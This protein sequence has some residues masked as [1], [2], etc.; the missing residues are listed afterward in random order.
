MVMKQNVMGKNLTQTIRNSITRYVAIVLIIALGAAMFVGLRTTK[1]DM[2]A[3]GQKYMDDQRMFDLRLLSTYG[4]D[5]DQVDAVKT[6]AGVEEAEGVITMDVI[7]SREDGREGVYKLYAIPQTLDQV[8][9]LGGR[10]PQAANECLA[11]GS[12]VGDAVLG[13]TYTISEGNEAD[14]LDSLTQRTFTVVGYISTPLF[15]DMNRGTTT[16]GNGTVTTYLYLPLEAFDVDYYTEIHVTLEGSHTVYTDAY[17]R[18]MEDLADALEPQLK[19]LAQNRYDRL[20][21]EAQEALDEGLAEYEEG[22]AEFMDGRQEA[23]DGLTEALKQLDDGQ[24]ELDANRQ[25]LL[26]GQTQLEDAQKLLDENSLTLAQSRQEL[27]QAKA[28]AYRQIAQVSAELTANYRQVNDGLRQVES[29]LTQ[30]NDGLVQINDGISQLESGLQTLE[31]TV[32]VVKSLVNVMDVTIDAAQSALDRLKENPEADPEQIAQAEARLQEARDKKAEYE[33]QL[34]ELEANQQ[35]YTAMLAEL[36]AQKETLES[37][38]AELVATRET[39]NAALA[40]IE[41]GFLE[42]ENSQKQADQ[43]FADAE[44]QLA[45]GQAQL[46]QGQKELDVNRAELEAGLE[47][48][49]VAQKELDAGREEYNTQRHEILRELADAQAKLDDAKAEL[50]DGRRQLADMKEP[51]LYLL[52]RNTNVGYISVNS[53]SDIV[54]GVSRVFPAF[55]LL[56]AALVCITTMTRMVA[57]ERTQIGTLKALGYGNG[58]IIGKYLAYAGS[59]AVLGSGL[60]VAVGSVVFPMILWEAYGIILNL[61]P[62]LELRLDWGLCAAVVVIYT[63]V[64]LAVTWYCCRMELREVPA[65]LIR[66]KAPTSGRKILLE[67]LPFW[68]HISFLNKVTLRNIF[69]YRQRLLMMMVGIGGCTALLVTGF[70]VKD[71]ITD[72]VNIQYEEVTRYDMEVRF[73]DG[74]TPEQ[75]VSFTRELEDSVDDILFVYQSSVTAQFRDIT[76]EIVMICADSTIADYIDFHTG[77]TQLTAPGPG[78]AL[79]CVGTAERMGVSVGDTLTLRDSQMQEL[80]VTI[81]G[82]YDNHVYNYV[83]VSPETLA[84]QWDTVPLAQMAY[85]KVGQDQDPHYAGTKVSGCEG[86]LSVSINEDIAALVGDM[87]GAMDLIVVV[88]V[89]CAG[90]LGITVCYNLTN[91]NINERIREIATIKVLGFNAG[92]SAAYVFKENLIL[93]AMGALCGLAGGNALL[94]FVMSQI[95]VDMVWF[96]ARVLPESY[97]WSVVL[98]FASAVIVDCILY[99]KLDKINMAEA[100]K[101]V[102]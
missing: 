11:D 36:Y 13:S 39:L 29:G 3:T 95:K 74:Q 19:P 76:N 87:L 40:Q 73:S 99:F 18:A 45:D 6:M 57:E 79:L 80:T 86:V 9:L 75:Q 88:V 35:E 47:A 5:P 56:I 102:E 17:D 101:S 28:D 96:Q 94:A 33:A 30:I 23:M 42:L 51:Q 92:E 41:D 59:A 82:I 10:L 14:T 38:K 93:T 44:A 43:Q 58:A 83:I 77:D 37:Q 55:F 31:I 4:W 65:E 8:R 2:V 84:Q 48:L 63:A 50:D 27:A 97:L 61:T 34:A 12:N 24:T 15:M 25:L 91:I 78:E 70:G 89:V 72:I 81:T 22:V 49:E 98:T 46:E 26:D 1:S 100:L 60:G 7:A 68:K 16:L 52:D 32:N 69:R 85:L 54:A 62:V 66:P 71:S 67:Y 21:A 64:T 20:Y 90:L 53:N